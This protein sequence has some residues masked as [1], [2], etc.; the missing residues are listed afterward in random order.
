MLN[1]ICFICHWS[2]HIKLKRIWPCE[3]LHMN[4][5]LTFIETFSPS[6]TVFEIFNFKLLRYGPCSLF[7]RGHQRSFFLPPISNP[8]TTS[9]LIYFDTF[10]LSRTVSRYLTS[11]FLGFDLDLWPSEVNWSQ[12]CYTIR[13]PIYDF[14]SDF[15]WPPT[16]RSY[17]S[18]K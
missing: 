1:C 15:Y 12:I 3:S 7:L 17:T 4:Y 11:K 6:R 10:T 16:I 2:N 9:Y 5:N 13:K 14:L 8:Y 18:E